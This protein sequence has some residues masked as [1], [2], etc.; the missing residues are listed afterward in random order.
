MFELKTWLKE[1]GLSAKEL[2]ELLEVPR[3]TVEDWVSE[4]A[5]P[6]AQN[7][8]TLNNFIAAACAH[9][10]VLPLPNGPINEGECQRCGERRE[11]SNSIDSVP[12]PI[13][14]RS[15]AE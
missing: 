15:R 14:Q 7:L 13:S 9:H 4:G 2:A 10:W 8:Y 5:V 11:F 6:M 1:Q 3:K 12:W